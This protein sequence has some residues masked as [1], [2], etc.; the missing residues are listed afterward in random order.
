MTPRDW[1]T[2]VVCYEVRE[3]TLVL[4]RMAHGS[5]EVAICRGCLVR[6]CDL[7]PLATT[8]PI[9]SR[10][11]DEAYE[12]AREQLR[13]G[14]SRLGE[15]VELC[16][17]RDVVSGDADGLTREAM[18]GL[19]GSERMIAQFMRATPSKPPPVKTN[20]RRAAAME[21]E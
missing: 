6:A 17:M 16:L 8:E 20:D 5:I 7:M 12:H 1:D 10:V 21:D 9:E 2:C 14:V 19:A 18:V 13:R 4:T 3:H 15:A 11:S